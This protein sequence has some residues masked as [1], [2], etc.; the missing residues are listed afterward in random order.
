MSDVCAINI[1]MLQKLRSEYGSVQRG[2][3]E[4]II[5]I[6]ADI[7]WMLCALHK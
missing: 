7:N 6:C 3:P 1:G 2:F 4:L 5:E